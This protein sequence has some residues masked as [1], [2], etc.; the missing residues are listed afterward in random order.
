MTKR[1]PKNQAANKRVPKKRAA[2]GK[3]AREAGMNDGIRAEIVTRLAMFD[4]VSDVHAALLERGIDISFQSVS[5]YNPLNS[6]SNVAQ[7]W[8]MLFD[9]TREDF[10]AEI[11]A[12]PIANRAYRLRKL[13]QLL[14]KEIT[15]GN[16]AG[17]RATLEQ[18]AKETGNVF[19]NVAKVQGA[20]L[21]GQAPDAADFSPQERRNMLADRIGEALQKIGAQKSPT[22][23]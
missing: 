1:A 4:S 10:L 9:K 16:T 12:E 14:D 2:G 11:A 15:R 23:Q 22:V 3:G 20:K 8:K 21:P 13:G 6:S 19:T 5:N 18:A 17:A 7:K